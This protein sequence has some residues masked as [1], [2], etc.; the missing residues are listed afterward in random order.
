M[1]FQ[2]VITQMNSGKNINTLQETA[3]S[4]KKNNYVY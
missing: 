2:S 1:S 3:I 4:F